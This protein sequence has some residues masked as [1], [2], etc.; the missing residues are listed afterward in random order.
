[1]PRHNPKPAL[2]VRYRLPDKKFRIK[3]TLTGRVSNPP[4]IGVKKVSIEEID[5][6]GDFWHPFRDNDPESLRL[7]RLVRA[8]CSVIR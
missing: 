1:M 4:S 5:R 3:L 2:K 8:K 7:R 6:V